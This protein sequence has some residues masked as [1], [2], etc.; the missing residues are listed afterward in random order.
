MVGMG[1]SQRVGNDPMASQLPEDSSPREAS[2]S[3]EQHVP[4]QVDIEHV[5]RQTG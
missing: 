3:I 5:G 1:V 2:S 4:K